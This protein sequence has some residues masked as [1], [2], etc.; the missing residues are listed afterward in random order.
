M[1]KGAAVVRWLWGGCVAVVLCQQHYAQLAAPQLLNLQ[2]G[3][4]EQ[5]QLHIM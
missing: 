5:T 4:T 3:A 1:V 2:H